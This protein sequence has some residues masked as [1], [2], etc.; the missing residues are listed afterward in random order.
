M[1]AVNNDG[2]RRGRDTATAAAVAASRAG[3]PAPGQRRFFERRIVEIAVLGVFLIVLI[4]FLRSA[5]PLLAPMTAA[6]LIGSVIGPLADRI[7]KIGIPSY[8]V[9]TVILAV[10]VAAGYWLAVVVAPSVAE[11]IGRL[12]DVIAL[13]RG[14]LAFLLKPLEVLGSLGGAAPTPALATASTTDLAVVTVERGSTAAPIA[15]VVQTISPAF[16]MLGLFFFTFVFFLV[17][18]SELRRRVVLSFRDHDRRFAALKMIGRVEDALSG[19][20][21]TVSLI[22]AGF[23]LAVGA[24]LALVGVGAPVLWG[25]LAGLMNFLPYIGSLTMMAILLAVGLLS[26]DP[27]LGGLVPVAAYAAVHLVEN[28]VTPTLVGRRME[29]N[30]FVVFAALAFWTWVWGPI[31]AFL[32]VPMLVVAL[33]LVRE[34]FTSAKPA[35]PD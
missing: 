27:G 31:G 33:V 16:A 3:Q 7:G 17:G 13:A 10:L 28:V 20:V 29:M 6:V 9:G 24:V 26:Y 19:Y 23:G 1:D 21:V 35:L 14:R 4:D 12:P 30:A 15:V 32:A 2:R 18:R 8:V 25:V 5:A 34:I 22:N 11:W